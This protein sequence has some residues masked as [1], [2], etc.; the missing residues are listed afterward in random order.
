V[1]PEFVAFSGV[2]RRVSFGVCVAL[3]L[4]AGPARVRA[5]DK[6]PWQSELVFATDF[7]L[8]M[9][10]GVRSL[11]SLG[12]VVFRYDEALP[13]LVAFDMRTPAGRAGALMGRAA[14]FLFIDSAIA[15]L[16]SLTIHEVFGHGA[17]ARDLR[18]SAQFDF[19][20]PGIYC[21]LL[22]DGDNCTAHSKVSGGSGARDR[23]LLVNAG[24]IEAD[25]LTA[26]WVNMRTV[27][28]GGWMHQGDA[29]VY[30]F[31]KLT[32]FDSFLSPGVEVIKPSN[33]DDVASYVTD[34]Q[35]RFNRPSADD[36]AQIARRLRY[37][38]VWNLIDPMLLY[39]N[40]VALTRG[41]A[42]GERW[43]HAPLPKIGSYDL[44]VAPRFGLSPFG[45]EHYVDVMLGRDSAVVDVYGRVGSSGLATYAGGGVR[46]MGL[47]LSSR[48]RA[49]GELD[50][51]SQPET[52]LD[53]RAVYRRPQLTGVNVGATADVRVVRNIGVLGRLAYKTSGYLSGQPI[54]SGVYGYV[55]ASIAFE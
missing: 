49:G 4:L 37:A 14:Q 47:R 24:G 25:L 19:P 46:A 55:G 23:S 9:E 15:S 12:R 22:G 30:A 51:W 33:G 18:Q 7:R 52:L 3:V 6:P 11:D 31:S 40:V 54:S 10:A 13:P 48:V 39:A 20:A 8:G 53:E 21:V 44:F 28:A 43:T 38:Y 26:H 1:S 2:L 34:L 29:L 5:A 16:E 50:V 35:D 41:V 42:G 36:R 17:R 27:R 45:A 32:Y